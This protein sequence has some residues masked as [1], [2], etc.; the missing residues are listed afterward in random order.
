MTI[1]ES[2]LEPSTGCA[3]LLF[4]EGKGVKIVIGVLF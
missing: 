1:Y 2:S 4:H 3:Q